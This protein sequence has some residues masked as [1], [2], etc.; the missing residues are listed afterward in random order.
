MVNVNNNH[1]N[2]NGQTAEVA[3]DPAVVAAYLGG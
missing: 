2:G 1:C 3:N